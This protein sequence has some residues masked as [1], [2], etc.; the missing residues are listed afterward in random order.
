M[1]RQTTIDVL[2]CVDNALPAG[3]VRLPRNHG[4]GDIPLTAVATGSDDR[5]ECLL[6]KIGVDDAE[7][8]NPAGPGRIHLYHSTGAAID[9]ATPEESELKGTASGG[10]SWGRYSQVLLPCEGAEILETS[11]ALANFTDYA[12]RG[13][14][15]LATHFSYVWLFGNDALG[16]LGTWTTGNASPPPPLVVDVVTSFAAGGDFRTWL[17][18]VGALSGA[19]PPQISITAPHADLGAL[20]L[21]SGTKLWLSSFS[22]ATTQAV[23]VEMPI[24]LPP[25]KSCGRVI[26]SDFHAPAR[27]APNATFPGECDSD[28]TLSAEEKALEFM[29]FELGSCAGPR[30][31]P[32]I[33]RPPP[34][35]PPPPP[36]VPPRPPLPPPPDVNATLRIVEPR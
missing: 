18:A 21:G 22:P 31:A 13:G 33:V 6:R 14:R 3:T 28:M 35:P 1:R 23:S 2:P 25:D 30:V 8:T 27:A 15:V 9:A 5:M 10:G 24:P 36:P 32:P 12:N 26:F 7:F 11:E 34:A 17:A 19:T 16:N 20:T 4:E 29:L